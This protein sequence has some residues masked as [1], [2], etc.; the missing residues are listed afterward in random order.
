MSRKNVDGQPGNPSGNRTG[1][2]AEWIRA[3]AG[4]T[5]CVPPS[6]PTSALVAPHCG[7]Y[8]RGDLF[9]SL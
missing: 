2:K 6:L 7:A 1:F 9:L 3:F 8:G 5:A 4:M